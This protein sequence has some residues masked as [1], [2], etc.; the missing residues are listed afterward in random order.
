MCYH[1]IMCGDT[2]GNMTLSIPDQVQKEM[3]NFSE[4]K[5][6][7]VARKA[8]QERLETLQLAEKLAKKSKLSA[9]DVE[10]FS[11]KITASATKRFL[12]ARSS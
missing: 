4:V 11:R 8:I 12:N 5:W 2:M 6:S 10:D 7:E 1:I 9:K 3:K